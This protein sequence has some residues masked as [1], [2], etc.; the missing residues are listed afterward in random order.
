MPAVLFI[1]YKAMMIQASPLLHCDIA[2]AAGIG[3]CISGHH[4]DGVLES[5][6]AD[7]G[8]MH[9]AS[10]AHQPSPPAR[11]PRLASRMTSSLRKSS[12]DIISSF[13]SSHKKSKSGDDFDSVAD[14]ARLVSAEYFA[15]RH[16]HQEQ[17]QEEEELQEQAPP[18]LSGSGRAFDELITMPS[19]LDGGLDDTVTSLLDGG[20]DALAELPNG[21]PDCCTA[22]TT[23]SED[24]GVSGSNL[25]SE[26]A[27]ALEVGLSA[28][29]YL[30]ECFYTEVSVLDRDKFNGIRGVVKSDFT[31]GR[32]LGRGTY[33]DVFEV[34]L[35]SG[36]FGANVGAINLSG[37]GG[38]SGRRRA[39]TARGRRASLSSSITTA[40]LAR[41]SQCGDGRRVLAMK[42]LRPQIRANAEEFFVGECCAQHAP[43][44]LAMEFSLLPPFLGSLC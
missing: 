1:Q 6:G 15:E 26:D 8:S 24:G 41:P 22:A 35:K 23:C 9:Q 39:P 27:L 36:K 30:E 16:E 12:K 37:S 7:G 19:L 31:I 33:S 18:F 42:C 25:S 34:V 2:D 20:F 3:C 4:L 40:T 17:E 11:R 28:H 14:A 13:S 44:W 21:K 10:S 5:P 29:E 43:A 38:S 32:H